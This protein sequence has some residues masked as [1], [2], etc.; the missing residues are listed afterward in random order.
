MANIN[1]YQ[2]YTSKRHKFGVNDTPRFRQSYL[3]AVNLTYS[4][5]N[6][7]VFLSQVLQPVDS[8][9]NIIDNRLAGFTTLTFDSLADSAIDNREFW[10]VEYDFERL[11][12]TNTFTDTITDGVG[13]VVL[14]ITNGVFSVV[15]AAVSATGTIP[16][17]DTFKLRF[18]STSEGNALLVDGD[19]IALTYS[20]GSGETS[21]AITTV[22]AHVISAMTGYTLTRT[23]FL[24]SATAIYDFLLNNDSLKSATT[25]T[26]VD[27]IDSLELVGLADPLVWEVVYIEP[28]SGLDNQYLSPFNM[29]LDFHLQDGGEWAIEP[30]AERERKWYGRGIRNAKNIRQHNTTY[31]DPLGKSLT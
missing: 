26:L 11:S 29:G 30:E 23:R 17:L 28:S 27:V 7:D 22:S 14:S 10:S 9:D 19:T 6:S 15:G 16:N 25:D 31:V 12:D 1:L 4:E 2:S 20:T 24:S 8:F 13:T 5:L 21:Q 3:D 18:E